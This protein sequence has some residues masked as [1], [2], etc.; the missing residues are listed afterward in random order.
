MKLKI[1]GK[2]KH[3]RQRPEKVHACY[4]GV[5]WLLCGPLALQV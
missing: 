1:K 4:C 2:A 5:K 3:R